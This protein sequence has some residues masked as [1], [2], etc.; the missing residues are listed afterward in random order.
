MIGNRKGWPGRNQLDKAP[1]DLP[2]DNIM[3]GADTPVQMESGL[4][5][6]FA[7]GTRTRAGDG[8]QT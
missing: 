3:G 8:R 4:E 2:D 5:A 1:Q 7:R 6:R